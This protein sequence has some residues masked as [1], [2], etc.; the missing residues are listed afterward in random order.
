[1]TVYSILQ[2]FL[3]RNAFGATITY[4]FSASAGKGH[5]CLDILGVRTIVW[6]WSLGPAWAILALDMDFQNQG[7]NPPLSDSDGGEF[8]LDFDTSG[9]YPVW[10]HVLNT[11]LERISSG[12]RGPPT[13]PAGPA[14]G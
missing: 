6:K 10:R 2:M 4:L 9:M 1:M 12:T 8:L 11:M 7:G 5:W 14:G 13:P 3:P